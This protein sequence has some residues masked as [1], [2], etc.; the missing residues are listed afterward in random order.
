MGTFG[1]IGVGSR[2]LM[3]FDEERTWATAVPPQYLFDFT[4]ESLVNEIG[5]LVSDAIDP[6]RGVKKRVPG[7]SAIGGDVSFEQ[8]TEGY[9]VFYKHGLGQAVTLWRC[10]GGIRTQLTAAYAD[11]DTTLTVAD[12]TDFKTA[13][14][15]FDIIIVYKNSAG[16]LQTLETQYSAMG[17]TSFTVV[18]LNVNIGVGAW[19]FQ[20]YDGTAA[21]WDDVYTHYIEAARTLPIGLTIEAG[22]DIAHFIYS[23]MKVDSIENTFNAQE[24]LTGT[25]GLVGSAEYVGGDVSAQLAAT[26]ST[27]STTLTVKNFTTSG[28]AATIEAATY[29]PP[30]GTT[31]LND[32]TIGGTDSGTYDRNYV[33]EIMSTGSPDTFRFSEDGGR[34][35]DDNSGSGHDITAGPDSLSDGI[36]VTFGATTGHAVGEAWIFRV[37]VASQIIGFDPAG[38]TIQ[39]GT[40]SG[41]TYDSYVASTGVFTLT[42]GQEIVVTHEIDEPVVP[43][44]VWHQDEV[45]APVVDPLSSFQAGVYIDGTF[46][47]VLG[48]SVTLNNNHNTDK[49]QLGSRFRAGLP[50]QRR[51]VEGSLNIE[52]DDMILYRKFVN[53]TPAFLEFRCV[54]DSETIGTNGT[55]TAD[56]VYRQKH[57]LLPNIEFTGS[58]PNVEG[59][60]MI[61]YDMPFT[62]LRDVA[63]NMNEMAVIFVNTRNMYS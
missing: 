13:G 40:E 53:G 7:T 6:E 44:V 61:T 23:G 58:T 3:A 43:Q 14:G 19:I 20:S 22:R 63:N 9:E 21:W 32:A 26:A 10:D 28:T 16:I 30:N 11:G 59:E 54:D 47:E 48:G 18:D 4:S 52:F 17:A 34:S 36:T 33:V 49:Y 42:D 45:T 31:T 37:S 41:I 55:T 24:I 56:D 50:E 27:S 8:Q 5:N 46:Q 60:E 57:V 35:W 2:G 29:W 15:N 51:T 38:G 12:T 39:V 62:A 1:R 25:F